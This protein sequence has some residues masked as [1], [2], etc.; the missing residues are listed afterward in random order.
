MQKSK[1][2]KQAAFAGKARN[3][4]G[5]MPLYS[6]NGPSLR[7]S[8]LKTSRMPLYVPSGAEIGVH[9]H[10]TERHMTIRAI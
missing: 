7:I 4:T 1:P 3:I 9:N 6:A 5:V 8:S 10:N 2:I